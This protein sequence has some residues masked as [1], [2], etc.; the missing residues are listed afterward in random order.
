[1]MLNRTGVEADAL[2]CRSQSSRPVSSSA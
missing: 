2:A 1:V